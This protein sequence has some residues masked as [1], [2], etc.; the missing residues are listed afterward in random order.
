[1]TWATEDRVNIFCSQVAFSVMGQSDQKL[2][3][4][5]NTTV[6]ETYTS[7]VTVFLLFYF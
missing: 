4:T 2:P 1:M 7:G 6:W 3:N 5:C